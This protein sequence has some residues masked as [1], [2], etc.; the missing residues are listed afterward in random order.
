LHTIS[1]NAIEEPSDH[2]AKESKS[3]NAKATIHDHQA[4]PGPVIA[5]NLGKPASKEE[6]RKR[7]E[8]LNKK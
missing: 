2:A 6:L 7:A 8:E 3:S 1:A 4:N 5:E